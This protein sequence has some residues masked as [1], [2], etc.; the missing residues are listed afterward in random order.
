MKNQFTNY[1]LVIFAL[2]SCAIAKAQEES[3]PIQ[4][5]GVVVT[6]DENGD[7]IPLPYTNVS[8]LNT[9]RGAVTEIDGFFSLVAE[10]GDT[11]VFSRIG[12]KKVEKVIPDTLSKTFYSWYQVLS[13]DSVLLAEA[14]IYPWPSR[15]HYKLEFLALN[16]D[17]EMRK[18]AEANIAQSVLEELAVTVRPDG[19]ESYGHLV[20]QQWNAY[21]YNGQFQPTQLFNPLAWQKFI[22]AWKR[23]DFKRKDK[24]SK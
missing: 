2:F 4:F 10:Q 11:I 5:S 24:K 22:K 15:E 16:V 19:R 9:S 7:I 20:E 3:K 13:Q 14:V 1:I 18:L 6:E 21:R 8:I 23:G 12:F 17:N